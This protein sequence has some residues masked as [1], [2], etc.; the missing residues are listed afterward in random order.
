M[1]LPFL[2]LFFLVFHRRNIKNAPRFLAEGGKGVADVRLA[3]TCG[4]RSS[5]AEGGSRLAENRQG[6]LHFCEKD[7]RPED[8]VL[9]LKRDFVTILV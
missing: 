3:G 9:L 8:R 7:N 4:G 5:E 6:V 2:P 1:I